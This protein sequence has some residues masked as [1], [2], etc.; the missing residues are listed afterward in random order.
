MKKLNIFI[1]FTLLTVLFTCLLTVG[2]FSADD[3]AD[4][5]APFVLISYYV[6][7]TLNNS[8]RCELGKGH[9]I[10][11]SKSTN[12]S[13]Q[14]FYGWFSD[15]G[16]LYP[17]GTHVEFTRDTKLYEAWGGVANTE[18]EFRD[19]IKR[20]W[21]YTKLNT[22]I[23]TTTY[24]SIANWSVAVID[25]NGHTINLTTSNTNGFS[26]ERNG[27]IILGEGTINF[28]STASNPE[29]YALLRMK[30][31]GYG[32]TDQGGI[33]RLWIGKDV[34]INTN[35]FLAKMDND[36][37]SKVGLP[38][39]RIYGQVDCYGISKTMGAKSASCDIYDGS[40]VKVHGPY[41]FNDTGL[42]ITEGVMR[43]NFYGGKIYMDDTTDFVPKD[44]KEKFNID[45][46]GG[47]YNRNL[48]NYLST[49]FRFTPTDDGMYE[50]SENFCSNPDSPDGYHKYR[51]TEI[52]VDCEHDGKVVYE[53]QYCNDIYEL[54]RLAMDHTFTTQTAQEVINTEELTQRG[55]YLHTCERCGLSYT[56]YI[57]PDPSTTYITV[58]ARF[59]GKEYDLRLP[60]S[61]FFLYDS[62]KPTKLMTYVPQNFSAYI[63]NVRQ[64]LKP[65]NL[66]SI[67][68]PLGTTEINGGTSSGVPIGVFYDDQYFEEIILPQSLQRVGQY[69][70]AN[71]Q[72]IKNITGIEYISE[73]IDSYAFSQ[74]ADN[75]LWYKEFV[76]NAKTVNGY[77]FRNISF[78]VVRFTTNVGSVD[79]NAFSLN[80]KS[81]IGLKEIIVEGLSEHEVTGVK[82]SAVRDTYKIFTA[83]P[84]GGEFGTILAYNDHNYVYDV[85]EATC[86]RG[87]YTAVKCTQCGDEYVENENSYVNPSNHTYSTDPN[88]R[89]YDAPTCQKTGGYYYTC[90]NGCGFEYRDGDP[91][92]VDPNAH[93]WQL[94]HF[95]GN[96]TDIQ[97]DCTVE[98]VDR[99]ICIED[100]CGYVD[101][102]PNH[103]TRHKF[104][105]HDFSIIIDEQAPTCGDIGYR[106]SK[107]SRCDQLN[108]E[109]LPTT[110][111]HTTVEDKDQYIAPTCT[112]EGQQIYICA[113]CGHRLNEGHTVIAIDP[114]AHNWQITESEPDKNGI[115][116]ISYTCLNGCGTAHVASDSE[117][118]FKT[119]PNF[120]LAKATQ[121]DKMPVW[122]IIL[123]VAGGVI[124]VVGV[125]ATVY[126]TIFKKKNKAKKYKYNFH[127]LGKK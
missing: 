111:R 70:F 120:L 2:I 22:D 121:G 97:R 36:I 119:D 100:G 19:A 106:D 32:D 77:A 54:E 122:A 126:F 71:M 49:K 101:N 46:L 16:V 105:S 85:F 25:L 23:T 55:E 64:T 39:I 47:L 94:E 57:Y 117:P 80:G 63:E 125:L 60:A 27:L 96:R 127:T 115:I 110:G 91:I 102:D 72:S 62:D 24:F 107:C 68:I 18:Q 74:N 33:E 78:D 83:A 30:M 12:K 5:D 10:A 95:L 53:C 98:H 4:P 69:A 11:G 9:T 90:L 84:T 89:R 7:G 104:D 56:E 34:K 113:V 123:I 109:I 73:Y 29:N 118:H 48:A 6:N 37:S 99:N 50:I 58:R 31:H 67:E 14:T 8:Q 87:S 82:M 26:E 13:G 92:P 112:S 108:A 15:D 52:T 124:L 3:E 81:K 93:V 79:A 45:L 42:N 1:F 43:V 28:T 114:N 65:E 61:Q 20:G 51:A 21:Y 103:W 86:V 75:V 35:T 66:I 41:M 116:T 88:D 76:I 38:T 40:I 44:S 59:N 17:T